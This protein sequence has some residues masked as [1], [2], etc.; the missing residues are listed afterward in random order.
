MVVPLSGKG[1][2]GFLLEVVII[3]EYY[4][5]FIFFATFLPSQQTMPFVLSTALCQI[6]ERVGWKEVLIDRR[7]VWGILQCACSAVIWG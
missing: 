7:W 4:S 2:T 1:G 5:Y 6:S 3:R